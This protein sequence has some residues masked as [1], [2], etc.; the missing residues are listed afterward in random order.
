MEQITDGTTVCKRLSSLTEERRCRSPA[1]PSAAGEIPRMSTRAPPTSALTVEAAPIPIAANGT[2]R[3]AISGRPCDLRWWGQ[4]RH[5][6]SLCRETLEHTPPRDRTSPQARW[7]RNDAAVV[8]TR[9]LITDATREQ[10]NIQ[11]S[12]S[13][14]S[15]LVRTRSL[16]FVAPLPA[17]RMVKTA[18][19]SWRFQIPERRLSRLCGPS[20]RAL[21][22]FR[23]R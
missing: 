5:V 4:T 19:S 14:H 12:Q 7:H 2:I 18:S 23:G 3:R 20:L 10:P 16:T 1:R 9:G 8:S 17:G 22:A 11:R 6:V 21:R 13:R 15:A